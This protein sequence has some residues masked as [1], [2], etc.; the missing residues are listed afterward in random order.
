MK[1][2]KDEDHV[3]YR[4]GPGGA[5]EVLKSSRKITFICTNCG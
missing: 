3:I 1:V 4:T 5:V 2:L